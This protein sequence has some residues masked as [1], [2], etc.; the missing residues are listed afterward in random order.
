MLKRSRVLIGAVAF[1]GATA[2]AQFADDEHARPRIVS[3]HTALVA[4]ETHSIGI[5]FDID[6]GWHLYWDGINDTGF[7]PRI[8]LRLSDGF[9]SKPPQ[10]PVPKR[11]FPA[12]GILD[13]AYFNQVLIIVPVVVPADA[14]AGQSV[15]I[16]AD[17]EWLV[18]EEACIP[19]D[20]SVSIDLPVV[21]R[22]T[23]PAPTSDAP[24]FINT[25][26]RVPKEL[27]TPLP[28]WLAVRMDAA[29]LHVRAEKATRITF[30]PFEK[31]QRPENLIAEGE[32]KGDTLRVRF[33]APDSDRPG[34]AGV[35]EV[36]REGQ[37]RP[38]VFVVRSTRESTGDRPA[39]RTD[40][41][42][43]S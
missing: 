30:Y 24:L 11:Y 25:L 21:E 15:R 19:G 27:P 32:A 36:E 37:P 18:C 26:T 33:K 23:K 12:E 35:I 39:P 41:S 22:G 9:E 10:W 42:G 5:A 38:D 2:N 43:G 31:C 40:S 3:Q 28:S 1:A 8:K 6:P 17:L 29:T 4:G 34:I 7:A 13:H 20:A 16:T 14:P